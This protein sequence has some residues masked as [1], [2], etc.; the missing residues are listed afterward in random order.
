MKPQNSA[1]TAHSGIT[2][3]IPIEAPNPLN[4]REHHMARARRTKSQKNAA[5]L[6][7]KRNQLR[8]VLVVV[9]TRVAP[10][11]LDDDGNVAALKSVRDGIAMWLRIDDASP[12]VRWEY[13]QEKGEPSVRV[14]VGT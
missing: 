2:F 6:L 7:G 14:E 4:L 3:T 13:E 10:R 9:L 11:R 5:Y 8:P 12:L 1:E